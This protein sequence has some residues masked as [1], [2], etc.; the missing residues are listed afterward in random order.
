MSEYKGVLSAEYNEDG[1]DADIALFTATPMRILI[2]TLCS[3][4]SYM[5]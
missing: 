5:P 3:R 4:S 1:G 2:S